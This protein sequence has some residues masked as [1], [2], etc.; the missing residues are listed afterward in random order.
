MES[1]FKKRTLYVKSIRLLEAGS[2]YRIDAEPFIELATGFPQG[3]YSRE[4]LM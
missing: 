4:D 1:C 3:F 2:D